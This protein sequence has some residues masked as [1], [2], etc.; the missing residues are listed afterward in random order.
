MV[1][2]RM[3]YCNAIL[4]GTSKSNIQKLQCAQNCTARIVTGTRRSE[5]N[6]TV[7]WQQA[8]KPDYLS[9]QLQLYAPVRQ[10]RSSDRKNRLYPNSHRT[11][12][13]SCAFRNA[14]PVVWNSL[15]HH[16]TVD[17]SCPAS[18][19]RNL[20]THLISKSFRHWQPWLCFHPC[21]CDSSIYFWLKYIVSPTA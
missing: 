7:L 4:H 11:T 21:N 15:P 20:K 5:H 10:L 17:L 3:N 16:L 6:T 13:T 19:H 12:F 1:G 2:T 9:D 14:A 18:F 8:S